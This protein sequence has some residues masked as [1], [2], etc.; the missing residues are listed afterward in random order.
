MKKL[1]RIVLKGHAYEAPR[2]ESVEIMNQ[3]VLC[4]SGAKYDAGVKGFGGTGW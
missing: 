2:T 1:E 3:G 4:A